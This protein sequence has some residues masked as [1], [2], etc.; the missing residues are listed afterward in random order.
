MTYQSVNFAYP[1]RP[2]APVL[3]GVNFTLKNGMTLALIGE[4][5]CGK[6]TVLQLLLRF[7]DATNGSI[8][9]IIII[10]ICKILIFLLFYDDLMML[11]YDD[12][13]DWFVGE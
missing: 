13:H 6:S 4:S 11:F 5:G 8:V 9:C 7:Y 2:S 3:T 10:I 1:S 12:F